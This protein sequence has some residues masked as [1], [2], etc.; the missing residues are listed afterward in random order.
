VDFI[1]GGEAQVKSIGLTGGVNCEP[2]CEAVGP[3]KAGFAAAN[4]TV[5][6]PVRSSP[7]QMK[8][9]EKCENG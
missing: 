9:K 3:G 1:Q 5:P 4:E 7:A 8:G 6:N 2:D